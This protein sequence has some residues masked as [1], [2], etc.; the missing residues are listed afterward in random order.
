VAIEGE[1]DAHHLAVP[2]GEFQRVG[3]PAAIRVDRRDLA[4]VLARRR[5]V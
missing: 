4:V 1:G 3:A 2:A 5:P